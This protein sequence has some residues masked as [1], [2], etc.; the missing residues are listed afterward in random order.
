M[1]TMSKLCCNLVFQCLIRQMK[2]AL[3][4]LWLTLCLLFAAKCQFRANFIF[5]S[6][7]VRL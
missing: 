7:L 5:E 6:A 4:S 1:I 2:S 3:D